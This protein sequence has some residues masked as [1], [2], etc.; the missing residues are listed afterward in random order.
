MGKWMVTCK[1]ADFDSIAR[2]YGITPMLARIIRNRDVVEEDAIRKFLEGTDKDLYNP[3]LL[4]DMG[5][6]C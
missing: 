5:L 4:K 2:K 1:R 3:F 6:K